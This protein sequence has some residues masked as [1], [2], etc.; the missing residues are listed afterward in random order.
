MIL[1]SF[2]KGMVYYHAQLVG[3]IILPAVTENGQCQLKQQLT[4]YYLSTRKNI[5]FQ[6]HKAVKSIKTLLD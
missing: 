3:L 5:H 2:T 1:T 6:G 4:D